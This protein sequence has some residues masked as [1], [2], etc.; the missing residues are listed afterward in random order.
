MVSVWL[1]GSG[2]KSGNRLNSRYFAIVAKL[3]RIAQ[4]RQFGR[5]GRF[6]FL[7]RGACG[8]TR[9][10]VALIR[11]SGLG[12]NLRLRQRRFIRGLLLLV[13]KVSFVLKSAEVLLVL[14]FVI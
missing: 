3:N 13:R 2:C 10:R 7:L 1:S 11:R 9:G 12:C 5:Y 4:L 6:L 14:A 8:S